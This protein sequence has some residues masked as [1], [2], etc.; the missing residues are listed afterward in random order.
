MPKD[1]ATIQMVLVSSIKS[2]LFEE[3]IA[4]LNMGSTPKDNYKFEHAYILHRL[5]KNK[6]AL[7]KIKAIPQD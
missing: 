5:G 2:K 7:A 3:A 6:D 1:P 4:L